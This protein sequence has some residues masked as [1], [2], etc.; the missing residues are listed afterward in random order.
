MLLRDKNY[1]ARSNFLWTDLPGSAANLSQLA[2]H[3]RTAQDT[4][5]DWC[6][7]GAAVLARAV[8]SADADACLAE[9]HAAMA[10]PNAGISMTYWDAQGHH[11]TPATPDRLGETEAK[12]LDLHTR[13]SAAQRVIFAPAIIDFLTDVFQDDAVAFQCLYFEYGSQQGCHQDTAFVY[14]QPPHQLVASWVALEDVVPGSGELFYYPGSQKL[15]DL[16]FAGGTKALLGGDPDAD[17][18]STQLEQLA[19][20]SGLQRKLLHIAKGDALMWAAD[21]MHGGAPIQAR[22][23]R[24]S[25]VTHYCPKNAIVPYVAHTGKEIRQ[26]CPR[27]WV[28]GAN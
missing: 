27:G 25:L 4:L 8:P 22:H 13:L 10:D 14:V 12:V 2:P 11:H 20:K 16:I 17:T 5:I 19:E 24:R 6:T 1:A 23:T 26:V 21:L 3:L 9:T 18:Y 28:V 15:G 7:D